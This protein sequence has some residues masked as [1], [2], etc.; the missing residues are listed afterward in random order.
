MRTPDR[1]AQ[2]GRFLAEEARVVRARRFRGIDGAVDLQIE[3]T[4]LRLQGQ[5]VGCLLLGGHAVIVAFETIRRV[6]GLLSIGPDVSFGGGS[7]TSVD[8][9]IER[10]SAFL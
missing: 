1:H 6:V 7:T 10:A 4:D 3:R 9:R 2:L 5:H 8:H